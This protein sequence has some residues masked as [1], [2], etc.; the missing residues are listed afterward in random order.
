MKTIV[1]IVFAFIIVLLF[2]FSAGYLTH[3]VIVDDVNKI[4]T[5]IFKSTRTDSVKLF[6]VMKDGKLQSFWY[7]KLKRWKVKPTI[8]K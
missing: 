2:G 1:A 6:V 4:D 5:L 7:A 3:S 8:F